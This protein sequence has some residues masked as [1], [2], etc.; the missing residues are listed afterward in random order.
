MPVRED[1]RPAPLTHHEILAAAAPFVRAGCT[2][3]LA[4]SDRA[5]R[6]IALRPAAG[7]D[8]AFK[9]RFELASLPHGRWRVW[10]FATDAQGLEARLQG[11]CAED[12]LA[13]LAGRMAE[14][15]PATQF[16]QGEG[17]A[18]AW[19]LR[20]P[21][22]GGALPALAAAT[23]R[24]DGLTLDMSVPAVDR[25]AATLTLRAPGGDIAELPS[26]LLAVL[27]LRWARLDRTGA[28]WRS[29]LVL[30][31]RGAA[32]SAE[33]Q[34]QLR[35]A[36]AHLARTLAEPPA[37]F[38]DGR[39]GARWAVTARRAVPLLAF[40]GTIGAA[41]A[42]PALELPPDSVWRMLIFNAPPLML[43][44]LVVLRELPRVEIPPLPRRPAAASWRSGPGSVNQGQR[45]K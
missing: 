14:V 10:R 31:E 12:G 3:D 11:E 32:R 5:E 37:A 1:T 17:W 22:A 34:A 30:R 33:A 15:F 21:P 27:G 35:L 23:L 8:G 7:G 42:V 36:A 44:L 18:V 26:D 6:R 38:H 40:A 24:L 45:R 25:I 2:V 13:A 16:E 43:G 41:L 4:A 19:S 28:T 29:S 9:L 20:L 39:V